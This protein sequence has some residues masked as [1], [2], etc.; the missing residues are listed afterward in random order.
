[1]LPFQTSVEHE[2][3]GDRLTVE[4]KRGGGAGE[5][6]K[7][8]DEGEERKREKEEGEVFGL[9]PRPEFRHVTNSEAQNLLEQGIE[10]T[11]NGCMPFVPP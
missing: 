5:R 10:H 6:R 4:K 7:R 9:S 8:E 3:N 2:I 11:L 1:M